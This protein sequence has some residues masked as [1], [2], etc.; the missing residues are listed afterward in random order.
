MKLEKD[1]WKRNVPISY[2]GSTVMFFTAAIAAVVSVLYWF[3][4]LSLPPIAGLLT[5]IG[6]GISLIISL[7]MESR[8]RSAMF[9]YYAL[10]EGD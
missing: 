9:E 6:T 1:P 4:L 3:D 8:K 10:R 5:S 7:I 2:R